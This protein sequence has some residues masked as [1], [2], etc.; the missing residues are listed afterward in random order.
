MGG[1]ARPGSGCASRLT[2]VPV[3]WMHWLPIG[4]SIENGEGAYVR[5]LSDFLTCSKPSANPRAQSVPKTKVEGLK[6]VE[7][8]TRRKKILRAE[9]RS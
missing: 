9:N 1:G 2:R 4:P 5:G 7:I 3:A 8:A 6:L